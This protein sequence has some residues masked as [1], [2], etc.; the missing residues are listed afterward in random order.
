MQNNTKSSQYG[1]NIYCKYINYLALD[2]FYI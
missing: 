2:V 1:D